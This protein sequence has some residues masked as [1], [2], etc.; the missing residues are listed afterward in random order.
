MQTHCCPEQKNSMA[1]VLT[2]AAGQL[3]ATRHTA[4]SP[5]VWPW[6]LCLQARCVMLCCAPIDG[7]PSPARLCFHLSFRWKSWHIAGWYATRSDSRD[8]AV[9]VFNVLLLFFFFNK[10]F[11]FCYFLS[12]RSCDSSTVLTAFVGFA[13]V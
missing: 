10:S 11:Y 13:H 7:A 1:A 5:W 6:Q 4:A 9:V 3:K 8:A 2:S 12:F